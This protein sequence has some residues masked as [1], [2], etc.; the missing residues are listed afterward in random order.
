MLFYSGMSDPLL[1]GIDCQEICMDLSIMCFEH[2]ILLYAEIMH[3]TECYVHS[4]AKSTISQLVGKVP[5]EIFIHIYTYIL[6]HSFYTLFDNVGYTMATI[7]LIWTYL[8][9]TLRSNL[10]VVLLDHVF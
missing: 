10:T 8:V 7:Q 6:L 1:V 5:L 3:H 9:V 4:K 2:K